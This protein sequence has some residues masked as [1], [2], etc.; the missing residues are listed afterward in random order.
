M[1]MRP[2]C[3]FLGSLGFPAL[4]HTPH[5]ISHWLVALGT[6]GGLH[7]GSSGE[8]GGPA[9]RSRVSMQ[10]EVPE[11]ATSWQMTTVT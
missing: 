7:R 8:S 6:W 4:A 1:V 2:H 5:P 11:G 9:G 10:R 3:H